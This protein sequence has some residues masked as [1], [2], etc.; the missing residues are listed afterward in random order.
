VVAN[1]DLLSLAET[2]HSLEDVYLGIIDN[3]VEAAT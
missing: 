2:H 1:A 3:D